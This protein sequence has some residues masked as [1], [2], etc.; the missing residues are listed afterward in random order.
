MPIIVNQIKCPLEASEPEVIE[1]ALK[2]AGLKKAQSDL[3]RSINFT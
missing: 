3:C 2:L 1:K